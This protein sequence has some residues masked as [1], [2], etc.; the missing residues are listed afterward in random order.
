MGSTHCNA[1][2]H[3]ALR[4]A[5][6]GTLGLIFGFAGVLKLSDPASFLASMSHLPHFIATAIVLI[7]P[8][9]ECMVSISLL[10]N[11]RTSESVRW[12]ILL[13]ITFIAYLLSRLFLSSDSDCGCFGADGGWTARIDVG[14]IRN[15]AMLFLAHFLHRGANTDLPP[16]AG[17]L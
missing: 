5:A 13:S 1:T 17:G 8:T 2:S 11:V 14:I 12:S 7:L 10:L 9:L 6:R 15:S 4:A 16:E 3:W